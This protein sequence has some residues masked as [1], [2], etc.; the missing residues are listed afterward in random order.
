MSKLRVLLCV[1]GLCAAGAIVTAVP[2]APTN[3]TATVSGSTIFLT[4]FAPP[5]PILGFYLV[6]GLTPGG[7]V[8]ANLLPPN[9][10]G[11]L[12]GFTAAP[13]PNGTYYFRTYAIDA[14]GVGPPSNEV[15]AVVGTG[16]CVGPPAA[17]SGL[18]ATVAGLFVTVSFAPAGGCPTLNYSLH[19]GSAPGLSNL[20]I[21]NL[22]ATTS[23]STLAPPG[24]YYVRVIAQNG[25]GNSAPSNEIVVRVGAG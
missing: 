20:A 12:N 23:L 10:A 25:S 6:A 7:T 24:T 17:P 18:F 16:G 13:I 5:Q 1:V 4:W 11:P 9:P 22:G 2:A 8:A 19:A 14:T 15:V 3:M 21:V